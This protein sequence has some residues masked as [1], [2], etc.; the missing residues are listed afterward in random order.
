VVLTLILP[1]HTTKL[2]TTII[3]IIITVVI[4]SFL[5]PPPPSH[6]PKVALEA[7]AVFADAFN[8]VARVLKGEASRDD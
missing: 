5:S 4:I 8:E 7:D 3:I 2:P 1:L 6:H